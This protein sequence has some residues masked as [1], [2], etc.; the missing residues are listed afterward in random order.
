MNDEEAE[1]SCPNK[2]KV[3]ILVWSHIRQNVKKAFVVTVQ[4]T[5]VINLENTKIKGQM[6]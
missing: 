2:K 5:N 4:N 6:T 3:M 1:G